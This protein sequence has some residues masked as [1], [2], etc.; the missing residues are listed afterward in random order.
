M[1]GQTSH[2]RTEKITVDKSAAA[3]YV[4]G[5]SLNNRGG[6][7]NVWS[8]SR[9]SS[10]NGWKLNSNS[11]NLNVNGNNRYNGFSVRGVRVELVAYIVSLLAMITITIHNI[12]R[13]VVA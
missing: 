7:V 4:N 12:L 9:N 10:T 2:V 5:S 1:I 11:G 8:R 13:A 6:N 3:G